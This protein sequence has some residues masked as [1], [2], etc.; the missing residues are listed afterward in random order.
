M[1]TDYTKHWIFVYIIDRGMEQPKNE[2]MCL[3]LHKVLC[4]AIIMKIALQLYYR[5]RYVYIFYNYV[6]MSH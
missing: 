5:L 3:Q 1:L 4:K 2:R 6:L